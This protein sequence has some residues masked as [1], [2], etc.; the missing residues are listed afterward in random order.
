MVKAMGGNPRLEQAGRVLAL[1]FLAQFD[2]L[3]LECHEPITDGIRQ[4]D[5][6]HRGIGETLALSFDHAG[7]HSNDGGIGGDVLEHNRIGT[8]LD[9]VAD[10]DSAENLGSGPDNDVTAERRMPFAPLLSFAPKR[11]TLKEGHGISD[12]CRFTDY[13]PHS[14]IEEEAGGDRRRWMDFD[15]RQYTSSLRNEAGKKRDTMGLE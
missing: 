5:V 1:Q 7:R 12:L 13:H 2:Q 6:V 15:P 10:R 3:L 14:M 9:I 11:H 4:V 8:N